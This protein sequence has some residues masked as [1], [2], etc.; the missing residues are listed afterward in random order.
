MAVGRS[1]EAFVQQVAADIAAPVAL[2]SKQELAGELFGVSFFDQS[3][4]S[5]FITLVTALEALFEPAPR[6]PDVQL[7]ID[8][9]IANVRRSDFDSATKQSI[10]GSM[11][12]LKS[13]SIGQTGR[14]L[15][16]RLLAGKSYGERSPSAFFTFCYELRSSIVHRGKLPEG[17]AD[18][19]PVLSMTLQFVGDLLLA[20]FAEAQ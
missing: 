16:T 9:M 5:R 14:A 15:A 20:S 8:E 17:V 12:W 19:L 13:E 4:R 6:H 2:T 10:C 11:E 1:V 3:E 18:L 7:F